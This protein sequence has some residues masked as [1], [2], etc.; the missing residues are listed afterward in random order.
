[1]FA[2][3]TP[4]ATVANNL[5]Y[6]GFNEAGACLP[7]KHILAKIH[8]MAGQASMR[9]GH[10]CP[11]N[12]PARPRRQRRQSRFNEAGA[13]LPRKRVP[14]GFGE[15]YQQSFNEAGACLPRKRVVASWQD[16]TG[17][18]LQ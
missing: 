2:P 1:M 18:T 14:C 15:G 3:E 5:D 10:V 12:A 11:G 17:R 8:S 6:S 13:C 16:A 7:R 4:T 9:P